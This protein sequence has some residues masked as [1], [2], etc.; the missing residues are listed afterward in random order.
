MKLIV[1]LAG[2]IHSKW[3]EEIKEKQNHFNYP[4]ILSAQWKIMI[5]P[6]ELAKKF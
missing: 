6:M 4:L 3:R 1:Y 2:E 5:A